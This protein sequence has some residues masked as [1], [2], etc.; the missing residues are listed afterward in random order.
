M[1]KYANRAVVM[2]QRPNGEPKNEDFRIEEHTLPELAEAEILVRT[3]W[4]SLDPYMRPRHLFIM[5]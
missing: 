4:L 5:L 1:T 2:A 3:L